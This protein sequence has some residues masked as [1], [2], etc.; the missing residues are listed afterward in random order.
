MFFKGVVFRKVFLFHRVFFL[1]FCFQN[2]FFFNFF[3]KC[4]VFQKS[5]FSLRFVFFHSS[6]LR[7]V[8]LKGFFFFKKFFFSKYFFV[9]KVVFFFKMFF[10]FQKKSLIFSLCFQIFSTGFLFIQFSLFTADFLF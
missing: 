6:S 10:F 9:Q 7:D 8:F 2:V 3:F 5:C 1:T 4:L